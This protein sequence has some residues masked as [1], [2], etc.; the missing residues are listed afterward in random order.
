[1]KNIQLISRLALPVLFLAVSTV[2][3]F[4][5]KS[6]RNLRL[7]DPVLLQVEVKVYECNNGNKTL[8]AYNPNHHSL[9]YYDCGNFQ[10]IWLRN[11]TA[12]GTKAWLEC[13]TPGKYHV[14]VIDKESGAVGEQYFTIIRPQVSAISSSVAAVD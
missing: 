7:V 4:A 2:S 14:T 11:G 13:A 5:Q 12:V 10:I 8:L 3:G 9:A 1:M 6:A